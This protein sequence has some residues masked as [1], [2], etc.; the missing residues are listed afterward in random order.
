MTLSLAPNEAHIW[1]V[2]P[3]S[4]TDEALLQSY[5]PLMNEAESTQQQ[6]FL[7]PIDR[8]RYLVTRALARTTLSHY[9]NRAPEDWKFD[10][11]DYGRPEVSADQQDIPLRF[12]ISHTNELIAMVVNLTDDAGVDVEDVS[13]RVGVMSIADFSFAPGESKDLQSLTGQEQKDRFF[14]Y[15]TLK[16]AYIKARGMGLS[17][18][19]SK[20]S[21]H[22]SRGQDLFIDFDPDFKDQASFWQFLCYTPTDKHWMSVAFQNQ[23]TPDYNIRMF[24]VVPGQSK[25]EVTYNPAMKTLQG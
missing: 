25:R 18:P 11:N 23:I 24:W 16:E 3:Q 8:H 17:L 10:F 5:F 1:L 9:M 6:R 22:R 7:R 15:W 4:I 21:F 2:N 12:N 20:F 19:L 14:L 13:R